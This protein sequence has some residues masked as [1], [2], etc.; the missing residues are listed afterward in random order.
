MVLP[1][2]RYDECANNLGKELM[3]SRLPLHW[4][5]RN[6]L[7]NCGLVDTRRTTLPFLLQPMSANS[8]RSSEKTGGLCVKYCRLP[9]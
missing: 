9:R 2:R 8:P 6:T 4:A 1:R 7:L 5:V 3:G